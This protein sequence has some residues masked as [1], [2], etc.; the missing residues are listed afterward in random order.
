MLDKLTANQR[1]MLAVVLS[2]VFF[3]GYTSIFPPVQPQTKE[4][5]KTSKDVKLNQEVVQ[6]TNQTEIAPAV[7]K[8]AQGIS[9]TIVT[10]KN[11]NLS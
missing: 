5:T 7:T 11:Q 2:I 6:S 1:L 9:N 3:V 4:V 10:V 8:V